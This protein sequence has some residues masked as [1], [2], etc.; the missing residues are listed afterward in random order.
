M[1]I[2]EIS[3][4]DLQRLVQ[5]VKE[6]EKL[7]IRISV[8]NAEL[9]AL[10]TGKSIKSVGKKGP[11]SKAHRK[12]RKSSP[13]K[14]AILAALQKAGA[15]GMSIPDLA[16][17]IGGNKASIGVWVYTHKKIVK[18]VAPGTFAAI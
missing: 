7:Q 13:L 17:A 11:R 6:R 2:S 9:V 10:E 18:K 5:L 4:S 8:I 3:S 16:N 14:G 12:G 1:A 15:K